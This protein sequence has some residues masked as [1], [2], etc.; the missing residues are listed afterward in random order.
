MEQQA[1]EKRLAALERQVARIEDRHQIE[2]LMGHYAVNHN[3]KNMHNT[4]RFY[5]LSMPDV[6][7][8]I[9]DRGRYEGE[10]NVRQLFEANYQIEDLKGNFLTHWLTTRMLEVAG[11]GQTARGVWWSPGAEAIVKDGTPQAVWSFITY[12]ID[13]IK[14][15][16]VWKFWHFR[17]FNVV[18]CDYEKGWC[19]DYTD[20]LTMGKMEGAAPEPPFYD[21]PYSPTAIQEAIPAC[22]EPYDTWTDT[23]WVFANQPDYYQKPPEYYRGK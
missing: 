17:V 22:P 6:S 23:S 7:V 8:E 16:G 12:A 5:A 18:K 4:P 1:L 11:D 3:Q 2:I 19:R 15:N 14:E 13:F 21:N 20:W 10:K 9:A